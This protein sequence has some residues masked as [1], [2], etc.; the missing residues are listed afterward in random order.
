MANQPTINSNYA[1]EFAG[2]YLHAGILSANTLAN[3]GVTILPNVK[4]K[5]TL[6]TVVS[7]GIVQDATCDFTDAGVVTLSDKVLTV[8]EKQVNLQLCKTPFQSDWESAQMGFSAFDNLPSKFSDFFIGKMLKDIAL[9]TEDF[10]WNTTNGL[11]A[12][13]NADGAVALTG[14]AVTSANVIDTL[15]TVL[16]GL[17]PAL[18]GNEDLRI[19]VSQK[20]AKAYVRALG[21]FGA[22]GLG[23]NG[24]DG[25][26]SQWYNN[27]ALN[28]DGVSIFVANGLKNDG[29]VCT[30]I[31]N[32]YFG[33]GLM[34]DA[35]TIQTIDMADIDGSKNVRFI[36]RFTRG[37]QVGFGADAVTYVLA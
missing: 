30:T 18:Y 17:N 12:L 25:K 10:L 23:G 29:I 6:K 4:Y 3:N 32:L 20:V 15:G 8:D 34:D 13:L 16:D 21:G 1:G 2:E 31:S 5:T 22:Q 37:L 33:T 35:N 14:S 26:G 7:S 36:A 24:T 11:Q 28:F 19:F 9:D 27:S